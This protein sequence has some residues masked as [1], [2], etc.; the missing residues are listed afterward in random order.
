MAHAFE[1]SAAPAKR[2][3]RQAGLRLFADRGYFNS[4]EILACRPLAYVQRAE[5]QRPANLLNRKRSSG[6]LSFGGS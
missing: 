2:P 6:P 3:L 1:Y 5:R 4:P